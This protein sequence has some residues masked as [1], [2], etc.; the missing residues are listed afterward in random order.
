MPEILLNSK[1]GDYQIY[2]PPTKIEQEAIAEVL[3][4]M[5]AEITA[6]EAK[7]SKAHKLKQGMMHNLLTGRIR[8]V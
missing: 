7:L 5:D 1:P 4:E 2:L 6:L 3:S 8:L